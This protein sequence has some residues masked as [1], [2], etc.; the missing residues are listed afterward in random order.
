MFSRNCPVPLA[1]W[2]VMRCAEDLAALVH[3]D[4]RARGARRC[5]ARARASGIEEERAARVRGHAVEVARCAKVDASP[6]PVR[7]DVVE[8]ASGSTPAARARLVERRA[9]RRRRRC[10]AGCAARAVAR[11]LPLVA[12][13]GSA[14]IATLIALAPA[15]MP[16]VRC[17]ACSCIVASERASARRTSGSGGR[18]P[19]AT[20]SSANI[21]APSAPM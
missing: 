21:A 20:S 18:S 3:A 12:R 19:G 10:G 4:A 7:R 8:V 6:S 5:R 17:G 16:A 13:R 2:L 15:S 14:T 9:R 1:H 11:I